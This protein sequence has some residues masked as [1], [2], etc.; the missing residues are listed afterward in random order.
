MIITAVMIK[1]NPDHIA[2]F[3]NAT[4]KNH[5]ASIQEK[6]NRRFDIL[7]S[8]DDP[9]AFMLYEAYDSADT[10]AAHKKTAHYSEWKE[11]VTDWMAEP[12]KGVSYNALRP[13]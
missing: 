10:A 5:E 3:I 13:L 9:T 7:Q 6:G 1:V 12:R 8:P 2:D 4:I 11:K